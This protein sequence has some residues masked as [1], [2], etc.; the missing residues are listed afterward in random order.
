MP[1]QVDISQVMSSQAKPIKAKSSHVK[2]S[3]VNT[4]Q[5]LSKVN[6]IHLTAMAVDTMN[7]KKGIKTHHVHIKMQ[8]QRSK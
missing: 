3:Q 5:D 2:P 8:M 4:K 6:S 1:S 7:S